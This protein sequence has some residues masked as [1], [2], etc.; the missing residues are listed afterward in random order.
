MSTECRQHYR[1]ATGEGLAADPPKTA[2]PG[3]KKGGHVFK[4]G[5]QNKS[6][7]HG[8]SFLFAGK[9]KGRN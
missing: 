9:K 3:F 6:G 8:H 1:M 7:S 2:R 4:Q 5:A